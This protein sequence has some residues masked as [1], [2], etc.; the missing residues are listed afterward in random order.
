MKLP[1]I[2]FV[3]IQT[4]SRCNA[5]C[6][7]CPYVESQHAAHPGVMTDE[8]WHH[9]LE[10]L[11][12]FAKGIQKIC[13]YL[14][15]EPLID[16]KIFQRIEDIYA[17]FPQTLV[18]ISTNGAALTEKTVDRLY[19][20][21]T[22]PGRRHEIWVSHHGIDKETFTHIMQIDYERATKNLLYLLRKSDGKL[23][24]KIRGAGESRDGKHTYFTRQQ[25]IDYWT[26]RFAEEGINTTNVSLDAFTFHDR[27]GTL[28]RQDRNAY[29]LNVGK[30]REIGPGHKPFY[31]PRLDQ[32]IHIMYDGRIRL[33]CMDYHGEVE[34]PSLTDMTLVE[35]FQSPYYS[36]LVARVTGK[37]ASD[38]N[39]I[40]KRCISPGG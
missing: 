17:Y 26:R 29:K 19:D 39:F 38:P 14:M 24:I 30:V 37:K 8:M 7:M 34:L 21:W 33:C 12:P 35:Y 11:R 25:Y 28:H 31:C 4:H 18:E 9:V 20:I 16:K 23:R 13:P 10:C 15:Q 6:L 32:W 36:D 1:N 22:Q 3:Q 40:C 2:R 27:A 5:D